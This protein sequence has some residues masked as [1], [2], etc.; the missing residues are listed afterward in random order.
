MS[1]KCYENVALVFEKLSH[2]LRSPLGVNR[3]I[4]MDA[5]QGQS[6]RSIDFKDALHAND[7]MLAALNSLRA[8]CA[9]LR[10]SS[11]ELPVWD[12]FIQSLPGAESIKSLEPFAARSAA[13][14]RALFCM[15][16]YFSELFSL[17]Q[18][19]AD[20]TI[21]SESSSSMHLYIRAAERLPFPL[22]EG[23]LNKV[24][25]DSRLFSLHFSMGVLLCRDV[26]FGLED[27]HCCV[28]T[29]EF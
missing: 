7:E 8:S 13:S 17:A 10:C 12:V 15:M 27:K 24:V 9:S 16:T 1:E 5:A 28:L 11:G 25:E 26:Q 29:L 19:N 14:D 3:S 2:A 6:L 18:Q 20:F 4:V 23:F 21:G 22:E